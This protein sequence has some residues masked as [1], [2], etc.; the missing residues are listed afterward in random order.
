MSVIADER[1]AD[2][3]GK[4]RE[5][6]E[7]ARHLAQQLCMMGCGCNV[8][9]GK[10]ATYLPTVMEDHRF[11][12]S[13]MARIE[14]EA[15]SLVY[16]PPLHGTLTDEHDTTYTYLEDIGFRSRCD[17]CGHEEFYGVERNQYC[18]RCGRRIVDVYASDRPGD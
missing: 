11:L 5:A 15:G 9:R 17:A 4:A 13:Q 1:L 16:G 2:L 12:D 18:R 10:V 7:R 6:G 14:A 8:G 3:Q